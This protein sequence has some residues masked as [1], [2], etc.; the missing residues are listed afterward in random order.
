MSVCFKFPNHGDRM[1]NFYRLNKAQMDHLR[2]YF[3]KSQGRARVDDRR[4]FSG[5]IFINRNELRWC[6]APEKFGPPKTFYNRWKRWS[7]I[8]V[9]A[10]IMMG[11]QSKAQ[12]YDHRNRRHIPQGTSYGV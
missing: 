9:L 4:V 11:W 6:D 5:V 3:P 8:G 2:S 10:R 1:R 12:I 7:D